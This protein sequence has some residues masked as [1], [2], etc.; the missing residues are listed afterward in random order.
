MT[1]VHQRWLVMIEGFHPGPTGKHVLIHVHGDSQGALPEAVAEAHQARHDQRAVER[2]G[3]G[4][5][6]HQLHTHHPPALTMLLVT[7]RIEG[8]P[9]PPL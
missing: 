4:K 2:H 7:C 9:Q 3:H 8:R 5:A 1:A 6:H